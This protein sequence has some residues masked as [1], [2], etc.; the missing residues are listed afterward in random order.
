MVRLKS[1]ASKQYVVNSTDHAGR[2][3]KL[4]WSNPP[5][6]ILIP[7]PSIFFNFVHPVFSLDDLD[8]RQFSRDIRNG[9]GDPIRFE[10]FHIPG[11]S[12]ADCAQHYRD[13]IKARGDVFEQVREVEKAYKSWEDKGKDVQYAAEQE[14]RGKLPGLI[15][16][17]N[18]TYIGYHG[19]IYVYKDP[20]QK[21]EDEEK[22]FDVVDFDPAMTSEDYDP[23]ELE[24]RGLQ[25]PFKTT[26]VSAKKKSKAVRYQDQGIWLWFRDHR[27]G[28][29]WH[30]TT[31]ATNKA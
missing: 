11:A 23:G 31:S 5:R 18:G 29:W 30:L 28:G 13:E 21:R 27:S 17:Q 12:D 2:P 25:P 24:K 4:T 26:R 7:L 15:S 22:S 6:D 1:S 14:P 20:T 8:M 3:A 9:D 19:V 10:M 16:S